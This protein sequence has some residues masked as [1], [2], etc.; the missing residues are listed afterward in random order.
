[1]IDHLIDHVKK[2][3]FVQFVVAFFL[4]L[5]FWWLSMYVRGLMDAPENN[6]FTLTYPLLSLVGGIAGII[7]ANKWGGLKSLLGRSMTM[8]SY[9]LLAQFFGQAM[10]AYY[11]YIKGIE[12][13]Y[14]SWGDLG[15]FGSVIF[16]IFGAI[17]LAKVSGL[18]FTVKSVHGKIQAIFIPLLLLVLSYLY[19]LRSYE[20]DFSDKLRIFLDFG[21]PLGQAVYL[22]IAILALLLSRNFLSGIMKKPIIF[23]IF[24]LVF[25]YFSDFMFIYQSNME[26]WY[27]GGVNDYFYFI[28]YFLMTIALVYFGSIYNKLRST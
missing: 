20:F 7:F 15:Y 22:S 6:Y 25:Q 12:V 2:S 14:P 10:Y 1:M 8:F 4:C 13:P 19:F 24:A 3:L 18:K 17:L 21:Y 23:L 11:I 16:Y 27:V 9:G 26:T 5:S 28:S